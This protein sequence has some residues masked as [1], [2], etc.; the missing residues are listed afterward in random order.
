MF[1]L[2]YMK[3]N[4]LLLLIFVPILVYQLYH[5]FR[6]WK[7]GLEADDMPDFCKGK[8]GKLNAE[9]FNKKTEQ[10]KCKWKGVPEDDKMHCIYKQ[11]EWCE[12]DCKGKFDHKGGG[13]WCKDVGK[14]GKD[15]SGFPEKEGPQCAPDFI[16]NA[17]KKIK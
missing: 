8:D 10:S 12:K 17:G 2:I 13:D 6:Y 11:R 1:I 5:T 9:L 7:E 4:T 3:H 15:V 16:V 14:G